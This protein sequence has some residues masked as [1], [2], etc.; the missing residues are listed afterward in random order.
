MDA[1]VKD[2]IM[3]KVELGRL[4][5]PRDSNARRRRRDAAEKATS[6]HEMGLKVETSG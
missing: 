3:S 4:R 2:A 5:A 1:I 6:A